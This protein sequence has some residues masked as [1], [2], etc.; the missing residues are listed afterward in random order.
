M[1]T[2]FRRTVAALFA[3]ALMLGATAC[4]DD[5]SS[6]PSPNEAADNSDGGTGGSDATDTNGT[7][8][9]TDSDGANDDDVEFDFD[10]VTGGS[11]RPFD[12]DREGLAKSLQSGTNADRWAV[13]G[14]TILLYFES[15]TYDSI[16]AAINC[17]AALTLKS[18]EDRV[19]L[20]YPDG[21]VDCDQQS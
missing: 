10:E 11:D 13:E 15:G 16:P 2:H 7:D 17:S 6:S 12:I 1:S 19:V 21:E 18:D 5:D 9:G 14:D 8:D 20:V 4:S 3:L